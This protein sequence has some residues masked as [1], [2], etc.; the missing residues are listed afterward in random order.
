M[1]KYELIRGIFNIIM[2]EGY[3]DDKQDSISEYT[4]DKFTN[5]VYVKKINL[6]E[7][8]GFESVSVTSLEYT[9]DDVADCDIRVASNDRNIGKRVIAY[10]NELNYDDIEKIHDWLKAKYC[11]TLEEK[12]YNTI[13][14]DINTQSSYNEVTVNRRSLEYILMLFR[15]AYIDKKIDFK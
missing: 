11:S 12:D 3:H 5:P 6:D 4:H 8:T 2:R 10:I 1:K 13:I 7:E 15:K 9:F 14:K